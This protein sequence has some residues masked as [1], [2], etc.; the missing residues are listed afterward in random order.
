MATTIITTVGTSLLEKLDL[1][2]DIPDELKG[3]TFK[4]R[5]AVA[6][7]VESFSKKVRD[8]AK[9]KQIETI[10]AET[11]TIM[12]INKNNPEK[13]FQVYLICTDTI[14]SPLCAER[15]KS[16]LEEKGITVNFKDDD[17]H[18]VEGLIV[19]GKDASKT[20]SETGFPKLIEVIRNVESQHDAKNR[21]IL[22]IS[23]GYKALIPVMTI[24][25]QLYD[26]EVSY[27]YED[28]EELIKLP[29]VPLDFDLGL[30]EDIIPF[31]DDHYLYKD[32]NKTIEEFPKHLDILKKH[33]LIKGKEFPYSTTFVG[34]LIKEYCENES[35]FSQK[36]TLSHI[37][38]YKIFEFFTGNNNAFGLNY[39]LAPKRSEKLEK[40]GFEV[41][42][43]D[44]L[45]RTGNSPTDDYAIVEIKSFAALLGKKKKKKD[46]EV[47]EISCIED[48]KD[49]LKNRQI[50]PISQKRG[51]KKPKQVVYVIYQMLN[52]MDES[53]R[54]LKSLMTQLKNVAESEIGAGKFYAFLLTLSNFE[55]D[56]FYKNLLETK[57]TPSHL[58]KINV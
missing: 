4:E 12:Q 14:L 30:L 15:I 50:Q 42:E 49:Q 26:M 58:K 40:N 25:G 32:V 22:N 11:Q 23:G 27:V 10:C 37:I 16:L 28:S 17:N 21:P 20:F 57:V 45:L 54:L 38:E 44:I 3:K 48:I 56:N 33:E 5:A 43:I 7:K 18:V 52:G 47:I 13:Q 19:E 29:K 39:P 46:G 9:T 35:F 36:S 8:K 6:A 1:V 24:M 31:I 34:K 51:G 2:Y 41:G 55:R 53:N